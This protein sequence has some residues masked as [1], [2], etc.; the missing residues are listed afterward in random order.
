MNEVWE[1]CVK[2]KPAPGHFRDSFVLRPA[3]DDNAVDRAH[4]ACAIRAEV[5]VEIERRAVPICEELQE[6][7]GVLILCMPDI[8]R[9]LFV[10][11]VCTD[12]LLSVTVEETEADDRLHAHRLKL[13]KPFRCR[14]PAAVE[15]LR[16]TMKI[17]QAGFLDRNGPFM[18]KHGLRRW[19]N[20]LGRKMDEQKNEYGNQQ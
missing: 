12:D 9:N 6:A 10:D 4:Q 11:Q 1:N 18:R 14:L 3:L 8:H 7:G 13:A 15:I 17:P 19:K 2:T 16:D 20:R 5:T